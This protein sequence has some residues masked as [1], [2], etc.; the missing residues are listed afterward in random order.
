M[1][2][3]KR[4]RKEIAQG[5]RSCACCGK[6]GVELTI[7]HITPSSRGGRHEKTNVQVLCWDCNQAKRDRSP[8]EW[9]EFV[10]K[11]GLDDR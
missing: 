2:W 6:G 4:L 1:P 10:A 7:D 8:E 9:I 11:G 3:E 5:R